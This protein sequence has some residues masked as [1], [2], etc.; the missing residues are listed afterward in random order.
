VAAYEPTAAQL[1]SLRRTIRRHLGHT[2]S[3]LAHGVLRD[4]DQTSRSFVRVAPMAEI[5]RLE[6]LFEGTAV[7]AA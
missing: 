4:W 2:G 1:A 3:P 7:S 6:A 5:A